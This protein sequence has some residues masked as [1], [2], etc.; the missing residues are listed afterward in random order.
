MASKRVAYE[1]PS[2]WRKSSIS[3]SKRA[4]EGAEKIISLPFSPPTITNPSKSLVSL[5]DS[6]SA[7]LKEEGSLDT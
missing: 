3:P 4:R 1:G 6:A 5:G 7:S 2:A